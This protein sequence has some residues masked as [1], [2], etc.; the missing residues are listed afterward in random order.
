VNA[1]IF[2]L[3]L[4]IPTLG[5]ICMQ[6]FDT[7]FRVAE[8]RRDP[9]YSTSISSVSYDDMLCIVMSTQKKKQTSTY[10][11]NS[12]YINIKKVYSRM[13]KT[14]GRISCKKTHIH[15]DS[16]RCLVI[17]NG[18]LLFFVIRLE[19]LEKLN[20]GLLMGN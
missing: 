5:W 15:D 2:F 11:S 20:V 19:N 4:Q 10:K 3:D 1:F 16:G 13:R 6:T 17:F 18:L 8:M 12:H 9:S 7:N 14:D